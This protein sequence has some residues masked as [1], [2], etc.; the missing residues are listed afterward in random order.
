MY[1]QASKTNN[2]LEMETKYPQLSDWTV[3][4][5]TVLELRNSSNINNEANDDSYK[6]LP[7]IDK[8]NSENN[9]RIK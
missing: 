7:K 8:R 4:S 5:D 9:I 6:T 1:F 3:A 2:N